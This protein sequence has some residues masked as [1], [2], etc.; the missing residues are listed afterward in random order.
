VE[1]TESDGLDETMRGLVGG[2]L[3]SG[4]A[5][6]AVYSI[7]GGNKATVAA[8]AERG[9]ACRVFV[10]HDLDDDNRA[11]LRDGAISAELHHDLAHD[12]RRA[13]QIVMQ[14]HH[15]LAGESAPAGASAVQVITPHNIPPAMVARPAGHRA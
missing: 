1:I 5:I 4:P 14:A 11:L 7:G 15:A 13:C 6:A 3:G 2:A 8:F 10:G 9:R 12:M